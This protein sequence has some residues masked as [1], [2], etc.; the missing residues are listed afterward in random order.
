MNLSKTLNVASLFFTLSG[1]SATG[2]AAEKY[3]LCGP[4]EDGC[5]RNTYT[6]CSCIPYNEQQGKN[7]WCLDFDTMRCYPLAQKPDCDRIMI[8]RDQ[9][10]C[11]GTIFQSEP[12]P[13]C[14][15]TT[16]DFCE[17]HN[18]SFCDEDGH[19]G[20]CHKMSP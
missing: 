20:S 16:Q 1:F 19:P 7:A 2:M 18:M 15:I 11:L 12:E 4:D 13:G 5:H 17:R 3:I 14:R 10:S 6:W 9:A 8:H